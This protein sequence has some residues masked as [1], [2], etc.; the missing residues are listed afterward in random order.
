M[1]GLTWLHLSD[2][3]QKGKDFDRR[4]VRDALIK[5]IE[6]RDTINPDLAKLD[7]IVF[8]GDMTYSAK[9]EEYQTA[10]EELF[11]HILTATGLSSDRLFIV[12]GNHDID[13]DTFDRSMKGLLNLLENYDEVKGWLTNEDDREK[14]MGPFRSFS[15]FT[16]Q[17][18]PDY[19]S[20]RTWTDIGG[21]KI[22]LLGLN[23]AW[24]CGR[25]KD[26]S[27]KVD[28]RSH[29]FVGE[30]QIFDSLKM[31]ADAD[32]KIAV[33]HHPLDWL[34]E[35]DR[36]FVE[37]RLMKGCDFILQGHQ[38]KPNVSVN[39]SIS[40]DCTII[41][42]GTCYNR[43]TVGDLR[44]INAYN[45]V[46]LD[47]DSGKG[48]VFLRRW[49]DQRSEWVE[50]IDSYM[51]GA[52]E[53][54]LPEAARSGTAS[55]DIV[56]SKTET[57][58]FVFICYVREDEDFVL[59]LATNLKNLGISVWLDQWNIPSGADWDQAIDSALYGCSSFLIVLS[60]LSIESDEVRSEFAHS[61]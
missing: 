61:S 30:P 3:H 28:D 15:N 51:Q 1:T 24:A 46:H 47:F 49:S 35:V 39:H 7:F 45:F 37:V 6:G 41:P 12:P 9:P 33:L 55:H 26:E 13:G 32:I 14:L 31:I 43:R 56:G 36:D 58:N 50:D 11:E 10:K 59:K 53:F 34:N 19:A 38:H 29:L 25:Y 60:P 4:V 20:I 48:N 52:F 42:A 18:Q 22:S 8:S 54:L 44:Y 16:G 40:G 2:W 5:D 21:K 17:K 57:T 27:G 23:S